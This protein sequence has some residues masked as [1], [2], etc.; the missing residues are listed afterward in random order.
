M[1]VNRQKFL[2]A[3]EP[4]AKVSGG[5]ATI[6]SH[7]LLDPDEKLTVR[8]SDGNIF[9]S[10]KIEYTGIL[11]ESICLSA[12]VLRNF[13]STST[14]EDVSI[15]IQGSTA[16]LTCGKA[17]SKLP[18]LE[19]KDYPTINIQGSARS[20]TVKGS[21]LA[22]LRAVAECASDEYS[23]SLP[24]YGCVHLQDVGGRIIATAT[25]KAHAIRWAMDGVMDG[26]TD[27]HHS[28]LDAIANMGFGIADE[29][30]VETYGNVQSC[31][32]DDALTEGAVVFGKFPETEK[33]FAIPVP[34]EFMPDKPQLQSAIKQCLSMKDGKD[35][36]R[37]EFRI[38][39][40]VMSVTSS[41]TKGEFETDI[42]C[43]ST[44]N[45][46]FAANGAHLLKI[47]GVCPGNPTFKSS[48]AAPPV[49]IASDI[50]ADFTGMIGKLS[51]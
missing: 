39:D 22:K 50:D 18:F 6:L 38:V 28:T 7:L 41:G 10:R 1:I 16:I 25:D 8:G 21:S 3:I 29:V 15:E 47:L 32:G 36:P 27:V 19:G 12:S 42:P 23:T 9:V 35:F 30:E 2:S 26:P 45:F 40:G 43:S 33:V 17:K 51:I 37:V 20:F 24:V 11:S 49:L 31:Q 5:K 13:V 14:G 44:D 48:L 4:C 34:I 46:T